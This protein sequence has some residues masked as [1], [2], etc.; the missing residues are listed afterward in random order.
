LF[1]F[2]AYLRGLI[3]TTRANQ[4]A[5]EPFGKR[6]RFKRHKGM[7]REREDRSAVDVLAVSISC[8]AFA[9]HFLL[10]ARLLWF[11]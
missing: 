2:F 11:S 3:C 4:S 8:D 7:L 9:R 6:L 10:P 1:R 5:A